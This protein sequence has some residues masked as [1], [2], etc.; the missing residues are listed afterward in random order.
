M[1]EQP[2]TAGE[3]KRELDKLPDD[4]RLTI[5][6]RTVTQAHDSC[7]TDVRIVGSVIFACLP[8]G[9]VVS[10]RKGRYY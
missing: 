4:T 5:A 10:C 7:Y 6:V 2:M 3:L 8:E 1:P 9:Y